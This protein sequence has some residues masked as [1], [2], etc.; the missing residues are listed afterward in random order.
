MELCTRW[1]SRLFGALFLAL[2]VFG[3]GLRFA[4]DLFTPPK[5]AFFA[6]ETETFR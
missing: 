1:S 5:E 2:L 4:L 3:V 6:T